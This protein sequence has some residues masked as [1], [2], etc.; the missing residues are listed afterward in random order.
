MLRPGRAAAGTAGSSPPRYL[1]GHADGP[2]AAPSERNCAK[3]ADC[4]PKPA[5]LTF[6]QAAAVLISGC[7]ALQGLRDAGKVQPGQK[8]LVI[9]AAGAVA[10]DEEPG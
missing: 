8:V 2:G 10:P 1:L 6:E 4:A 7:T 9:G 5:N 3:E